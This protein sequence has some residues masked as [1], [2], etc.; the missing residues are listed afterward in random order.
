[1]AHDQQTI[2]QLERDYRREE[3]HRD[4]AIRMIAKERCPCEGG[5]LLRAIY[6]ARLEPEH[7]TNIQPNARLNSRRRRILNK[8]RVADFYSAGCRFRVL[9]GS[10]VFSNTYGPLRPQ[11]HVAPVAQNSAV[12]Q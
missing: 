12:P 11:D 8:I 9:L 7:L 5:P 4:N 10:P 6:L 2:E 3:V 1:M